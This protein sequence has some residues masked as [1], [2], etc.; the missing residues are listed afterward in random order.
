MGFNSAFKGLKATPALLFLA[1]FSRPIRSPNCVCNF[2]CVW[3]FSFKVSN[4]G[5]ISRNSVF[6]TLL[7]PP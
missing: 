6:V 5:L 3:V 7:E 2:V 1:Y 4:Q